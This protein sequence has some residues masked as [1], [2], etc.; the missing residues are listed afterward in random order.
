MPLADL[1]ARERKVPVATLPTWTFVRGVHWLRL[2]RWP[3]R[4]ITIVSPHQRSRRVGF[5]DEADLIMFQLKFE[6][7]MVES[8]WALE[9]FSPERPLAGIDG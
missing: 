6:A 7:H 3:D 5:D 4:S 9:G 2:H 8:G 1:P